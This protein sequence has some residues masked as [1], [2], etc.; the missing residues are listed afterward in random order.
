MSKSI[1]TIVTLAVLNGTPALAQ[2]FAFQHGRPAHVV[3]PGVLPDGAPYYT[4]ISPSLNSGLR[5][6]Q[7]RFLSVIS[8]DHVVPPLVRGYMVRAMTSGAFIERFWCSTAS[9]RQIARALGIPLNMY[10]GHPNETLPL[11]GSLNVQ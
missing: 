4:E 6:R 10:L 1:A 7:I 8:I 11:T 5:S 2:T 9:T 3:E